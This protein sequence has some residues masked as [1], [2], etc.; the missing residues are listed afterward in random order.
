MQHL[1]NNHILIIRFTRII[2]CHF[3]QS[4][5][6]ASKGF[7]KLQLQILNLYRSF[8]R[9]SRGDVNLQQHIRT[10]FRRNTRIPRS[11]IVRIEYLYRT[12]LR[13]LESLRT[14]RV[15]NVR[16]FTPVRQVG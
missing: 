1:F 7:S 14:S 3:I 6:V 4:V 5:K 11:E 2:Y 9:T 8:L 16:V 10:E 13:Q 15:T 12:G